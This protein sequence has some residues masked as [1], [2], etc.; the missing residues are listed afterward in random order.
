MSKNLNRLINAENMMS[1]LG[2]VHIQRYMNNMWDKTKQKMKPLSLWKENTAAMNELISYVRSVTSVN[3]GKFIPPKDRIAVSDLDGT[4]FCETDPTYFDF[5]LFCHR[6]LEDP[7]YKDRATEH[8]LSVAKGVEDLIKTGTMAPNFEVEIGEAIAHAFSGMAIEDFEQYVRDFG[9]LPCRG[10][11]GMTQGEAF[12]RPMLQVLD[13][14]RENGFIIYICSGTDRQV[15]RSLLS[16]EIDFPPRQVLAT[17]EVIVARD[18]GDTDGKDYLYS[19]NDGLV[20]GGKI[21]SK[22]LRMN[23][24]SMIAQEIGQQP[25]LCFGNSSG[26]FSMANYV[27]GNN[28]YSSRVFM[29]CC[30]DLE[31]ENGNLKKA[32]EMEE[33]CKKSGWVPISMKNDWKTIYGDGVTKKAA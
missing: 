7:D 12:Y 22:N 17:G 26:D 24:V 16:A 21:Q 9:N 3:S 20:L 27:T 1:E 31:R 33:M 11:E 6:V 23:K 32:A 10:Y 2:V 30:D 14:L 25:V 13:Y 19:E 15:V 18:Q 29:V 5:R 8:E 28:K 4:L